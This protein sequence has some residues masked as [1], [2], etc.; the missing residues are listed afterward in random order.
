MKVVAF[1]MS[2]K[3]SFQYS[4]PC[5]RM[6]FSGLALGKKSQESSCPGWVWKHLW[7][8]LVGVGSIFPGWLLY[9]N[10]WVRVV[11]VVSLSNHMT[12]SAEQSFWEKK[13]EALITEQNEKQNYIYQPYKIIT[14]K[15]HILMFDLAKINGLSF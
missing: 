2:Q 3:Q 9:I 7:P 14:F 5:A 8:T 4:H 1:H 6:Q 15:K 12:F 13:R 10:L 11:G